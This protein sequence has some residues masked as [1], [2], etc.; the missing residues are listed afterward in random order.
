MLRRPVIL[1]ALVVL[2][3]FGSANALITVSL[4]Q[5]FFELETKQYRLPVGILGKIANIESNGNATIANTTSTAVGMFQWTEDSWLRATKALYGSSLRLESRR[6][7][8]TSAKVTAFALR[9]TL[10][11][12]EKLFIQAKIDPSLGLYLGHFLGQAGSVRFIAGYMQTPNALASTVF[13]KETLYNPKIFAGKTYTDILNSFAAKLKVAGVAVNVPG[14]YVDASGISLAFSDADVGMNE[15]YPPTFI[16]PTADPYRTFQTNYNTSATPSI[17]AGLAQ[18]LAGLGS[19]S[20]SGGSGASGGG[21][22]GGSTQ[23][24]GT[25]SGSQT[26]TGSGISTGATSSPGVGQT[27]STTP[28]IAMSSA[29]LIIAQSPTVTRNGSTL[30]VWSSVGMQAGSCTVSQNGQPFAIGGEGAKVLGAPL[31]SI[32]GTISLALQCTNSA[33]TATS[34]NTVVTIQ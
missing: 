18:W 32:A 10:D 3:L 21:G 15:Y 22:T 25:N 26:G 11:R 13:V 6:D 20:T 2:F 29:S 31:T 19:T 5:I 8:V 7:P 14:N 27:S 16:P 28:Q 4:N 23:G 12:N 9:E 33:G 24:S 1:G 30:I 17:A 34:K